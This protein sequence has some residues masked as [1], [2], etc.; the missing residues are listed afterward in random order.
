MTVQDVMRQVRDCFPVACRSGRFA[1][2][3]GR[4]SPPDGLSPG[5]WIALRGS[6]HSDGVYQLGEDGLLPLADEAPFQGEVW[7]LRPP[8]DFLQLCGDICRYAEAQGDDGLKSERF[9]AYSFERAVDASGLPADWRS[10]FRARLQ[11]WQRMFWR[12]D[13]SC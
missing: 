11:P 12:E 10:V 1:L 6:A 9:G 2:S 3:G 13:V 7:L 5:D 8:P 4:L